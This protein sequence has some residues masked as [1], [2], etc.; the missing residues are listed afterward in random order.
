MKRALIIFSTLWLLTVPAMAENAKVDIFVTS[1]CPYC[2]KLE[3]FL[4]Q[5]QIDYTRHDVEA[6]P[7]SKDLFEQLGGT[8]VPLARVGDDVIYGYDT[9]KILASLKAQATH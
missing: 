2:Q 5:N 7:Q 4:K 8:G 9:E 6:D 3:S 1:W